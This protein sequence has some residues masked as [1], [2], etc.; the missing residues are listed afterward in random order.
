M[1]NRTV[2]R[3]S[4]FATALHPVLTRWTPALALAVGGKWEKHELRSPVLPLAMD[5][6][7]PPL[8]SG[9]CWQ[10]WELLAV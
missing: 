4:P 7:E 2:L 9:A 1:Q 3:N 8:V 5:P 10:F 6:P